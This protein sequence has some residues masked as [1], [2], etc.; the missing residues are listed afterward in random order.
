MKRQA[1]SRVL[2]TLPLGAIG[3]AA[4]AVAPAS[5]GATATTASIT[6][7]GAVFVQTEPSAVRRCLCASW[8][9]GPGSSVGAT[10]S[11]R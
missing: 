4:L 6:H 11:W 2:M 9:P 7:G 10:T 5:F 1:V 3:V 8:A